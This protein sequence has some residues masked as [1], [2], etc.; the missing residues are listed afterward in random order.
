MATRLA[1]L[2]LPSRRFAALA[3]MITAAI[4]LPAILHAWGPSDRQTF[5]MDSPA[6]H[7]AFNSITD[8][9]KYGD[10]TNFV[11]VRNF[12]D[13]GDFV[14]QV[15]LQPG[16]EYEVFI[17]YHNNASDTLNDAAHDYKGIA[18][19]AFMRADLPASVSAGQNARLTGYVG[20]ENA[21][22][23][24]VWD[25]AYA[26]NTSQGDINLRIVP[27]SAKITSN[28]AVN[29]SVLPNSLFTTGTALGYDALDGKLPGCTQYAGYVTYRF[30]VDQ[31][32]FEIEK[33][34]RISGQKDY[35]EEVTAKA[36]DTVEYRVKYHNT[37]TEQ[38]D[39]VVIRDALPAGIEYAPNSTHIANSVTNG[40]WSPVTDDTLTKQGINIGSYAPNG[41]A[42]VKFSAKIKSDDSLKCGLNT[43]TN[44]AYAE[45]PNGN[46]SDTADVKVEKK[47][48]QPEPK[49]ITVCRLED[50]KYPVTIKETEFDE[51]KHSKNPADCKEEVPAPEKIEV[52]KLETKEIAT[53]NKD[54]F[55]GTKHSENFDDCAVTPPVTPEVPNTP[56]KLPETG[57]LRAAAPFI[58]FGSLA[59]AATYY[60]SSR[61]ML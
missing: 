2:R 7:V 19:G 40:Q 26:K 16:K 25:E 3:A 4:A 43:L 44:T 48:E 59:L 31:P 47:C 39:N 8:S 12:T 9:E 56:E 5:T 50:K 14:E 60:F 35:V 46:K 22:P 18:K 33:Q 42:Y 38:Q 21:T 29:G 58:G 52:C 28:G 45:T 13:N 15:D 53:I 6:D 57:A 10:E 49:D 51:S 20:A 34:V 30:V 61:R 36:G 11:Q 41:N 32:N 55:D 24:Q 1:K 54:D 27:Q 37:G 17:M 23:G